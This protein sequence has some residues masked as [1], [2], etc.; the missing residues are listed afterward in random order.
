MKRWV[1]F[2][3]FA[4]VLGISIGAYA[5]LTAYN[6]K[7]EAKKNA[8][9]ESTNKTL[10]SGDAKDLIS[11][12]YKYKDSQIKLTKNKDGSWSDPDLPNL[13]LDQNIIFNMVNGATTITATHLVEEGTLNDAVY[14]LDKP[15][16]ELTLT[17][18][19]GAVTFQVGA[20]NEVVGGMYCR[21]AGD[22]QIY[23]IESA[24]PSYFEFTLLDL[25]SLE[26]IPTISVASINGISVKTKDGSLS[27]EHH[28]ER[29]ENCYS[30]SYEWFYPSNGKMVPLDSAVIGTMLTSITGAKF[31]KCAAYVA[32]QS[33]MAKYG[34]DQPGAT[35]TLQYTDA[36]DSSVKKFS[37]Y[38]GSE[39]DRYTYVKMSGSDAVYEIYTYKISQLYSGKLVEYL[40]Q[41][42]TAITL[43]E[44]DSFTMRAGNKTVKVDIQ[45]KKNADGTFSTDE[46]T[47]YV[48]GTQVD[49]SKATQYFITLRTLTFGGAAENGESVTAAPEVTVDFVRNT[50]YFKNMHFEIIPYNSSYYV[51]RFNDET[52]VLVSRRD[53]GNLINM[54]N[55]AS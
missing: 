9:T 17:D 6:N 11:I 51:I 54:I 15:T 28:K 13:K 20:A 8:E 45:R 40:P 52:R 14:G 24:V 1:K 26:S 43:S 33:D 55:Q 4:L 53:V 27:L 48:N 22:K 49:T 47:Y 38:F 35:I 18:S 12:S 29:P 32:S 34:L 44:L 5:W 50:S 10:H 36:T 31:D 3:L 19:N 30:S 7:E 42:V 39:V 2:L 25:V 46:P 41:E 37:L 21:V 23:I 16:L